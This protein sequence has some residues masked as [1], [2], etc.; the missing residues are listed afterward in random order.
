MET[1]SAYPSLVEGDFRAQLHQVI[2]QIQDEAVLRA[3]LLLLLPQTA[4]EA[5]EPELSPA[6]QQALD[7]RLAAY[8][9]AKNIPFAE[10][11]DSLT[12]KS[13]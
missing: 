12:K 7:R 10:V 1:I 11:M 4:L 6:W 8:D 3:A 5:P 9:P 2:D 13:V